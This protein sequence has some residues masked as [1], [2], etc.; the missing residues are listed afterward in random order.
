MTVTPRRHLIA[1]LPIG[2]ALLWAIPVAGQTG[3][4]DGK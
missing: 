4:I 2:V 3:A 1:R